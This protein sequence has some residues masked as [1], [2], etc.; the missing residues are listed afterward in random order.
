MPKPDHRPAIHATSTGAP[1][2]VAVLL[3]VVL[4]VA[5][6]MMALDTLS[7]PLPPGAAAGHTERPVRH[8]AQVDVPSVPPAVDG[9]P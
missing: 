8:H 2:A 3:A 7:T 4:M 9:R 1:R 5:A 6:A